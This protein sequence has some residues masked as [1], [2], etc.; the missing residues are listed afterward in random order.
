[1]AMTR[2]QRHHLIRRLVAAGGVPNQEALRRGLAVEGVT[3]T[4]ATLSRDIKA[5]GL[6]KGPTGYVD[7]A[8]LDRRIRLF[9]GRVECS[10]CHSPYSDEAS[11]LV[12]PNRQSALCLS[13]HD[14]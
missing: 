12:M 7:P 8:S 1:M 2:T 14:V 9:N 5:L 13:C 4:Q 10:S 3:V 11:L 6:V